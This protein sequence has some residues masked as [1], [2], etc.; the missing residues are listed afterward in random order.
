MSYYVLS[1]HVAAGNVEALVR[2]VEAFLRYVEALVRYV[3]ALVRCKVQPAAAKM[4]ITTRYLINQAI[5]Q[6]IYPSVNQSIRL[7]ARPCVM[8]RIYL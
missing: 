2:N 8:L 1:Y 6:S 3:E 5:Y 4:L 7:M